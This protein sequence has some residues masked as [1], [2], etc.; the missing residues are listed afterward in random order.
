LKPKLSR[1]Q[2]QEL[3]A[4]DPKTGAFTWRKSNRNVSTG[5]V[6]GTI[7]SE[8]YRVITV[9]GVKYHAHRLA[10]LFAKGA[11]PDRQIDHRNLVRSDNRLLNLRSATVSQNGQN[12][13]M[14]SNNRSG[15]KGVHFSKRRGCWVAKICI[16]RN[17]IHLGYF[18]DPEAAS[19]AYEQAETSLFGEFKCTAA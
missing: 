7:N 16:Q 13:Q 8:G 5:D 11:W 12:R 17:E 3:L 4:Y 6:A 15:Y 19:T 1:A 18:S 14:Q 2:L 10:W 9:N